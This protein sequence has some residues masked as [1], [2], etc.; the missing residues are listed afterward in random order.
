MRRSTTMDALMAM[1]RAGCY[2]AAQRL[3]L[4]RGHEDEVKTTLKTQPEAMMRAGARVSPTARNRAVPMLSTERIPSPRSEQRESATASHMS[5]SGS[6]WPLRIAGREDDAQDGDAGAE[7]DG[8]R[9]G[10]VD[11]PG[12]TGVIPL[13]EELTGDDRATGAQTDAEPDGELGQAQGRLDA[14]RAIL[15]PDLPD[16][17]GI[18]KRIGLL[19]R[20]S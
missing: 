7:D 16:D 9:H 15:P 6:P 19:E 13:T 8:E 14:A 20:T 11:E 12:E 3:H 5:S 4:E 17:V 10:R 18:D 1:V 2:A